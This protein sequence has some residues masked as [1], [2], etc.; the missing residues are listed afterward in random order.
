MGKPGVVLI[1]GPTAS[2][3]SRLAMEIAG[4]RNGVIINA[5]AM[6][7]YR[8]L[9]VITAR[10]SHTDEAAVPHR[11]YGHV[12]ASQRYSV[13]AW[14]KDAGKT[15]AEVHAAGK[16]AI[17]VG[18]TG[19]YFKALT[20][21]LPAIPPIPAEVRAAVAEEARGR[22]AGELHSLLATVDPEDAKA[23]RPSDRA[24]IIRALEVYGATGVPIATW[25]LRAGKPLV[26]AT[27][28]ERIVLDIDRGVLHERI[29]ARARRMVEEGAVE[30]ARAVAAVGIDPEMSAMK[31]IGV[32]E[33]LA[34]V[35]GKTSLDKAVTAMT[36]ATRRYARRQITWFRNQMADW[37]RRSI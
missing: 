19:L 33:L 3:K 35:A 18:G 13:G 26:D 37:P 11:L 30:E 21:G 20:E 8:E 12:A 16:V 9:R 28:A 10:P 34:F 27:S 22:G 4:A 31:A 17:F 5:D 36:T 24:R 25:R 2:G 1:A 7:V 32:R 23:I 29:A 6:Q 14:L 15:L